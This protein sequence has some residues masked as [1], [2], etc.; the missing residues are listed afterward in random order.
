MDKAVS[1]VSAAL[2]V[3]GL[4][5]GLFFIWSIWKVLS[6]PGDDNP[7]TFLFLIAA[8]LAVVPAWGLV[9]FYQGGKFSW[10]G[11]LWLVVAGGIVLL[12]VPFALVFIRRM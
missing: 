5:L 11:W 4:A 6:S 12:L 8:G 1:L 7:I 10:L 2:G 3:I 9:M